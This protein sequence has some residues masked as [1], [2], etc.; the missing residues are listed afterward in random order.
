MAAIDTDVEEFLCQTLVAVISTID[1]NGRPRSAPIWFHWEDGAAYMFTDRNTLKWRN[2]QRYPYASLCVDWREPPYKSII[3]DGLIEEVERSL[4]EL[5]LVMALRYYGKGKGAEFA[6][7]YKNKSESVA[8]FRLIPDH[9]ANY[10]E[11]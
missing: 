4:Y 5:V 3:L 10:L 7:G 2:I 6:E 11:E 8:V 9:V 1:N